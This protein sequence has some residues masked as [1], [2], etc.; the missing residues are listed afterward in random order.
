MPRSDMRKVGAFWEGETKDGGSYLSGQL[1]N[2][3]EPPTRDEKLLIFRNGY[4]KQDKEPDYIMYA[5]P[6]NRGGD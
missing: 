6:R 2:R 3:E 1:D 5:A 4:K